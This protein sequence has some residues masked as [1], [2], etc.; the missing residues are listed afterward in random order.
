[1]NLQ[2]PPTFMLMADRTVAE[3]KAIDCSTCGAVAGVACG[4]HPLYGIEGVCATRGVLGRV[5]AKRI[6]QQGGA[7]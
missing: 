2:P 1:M 6:A 4:K 5:H 3:G 7:A